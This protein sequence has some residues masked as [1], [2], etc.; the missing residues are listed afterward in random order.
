MNTGHLLT[1]ATRRALSCAG[2]FA[3]IGLLG[4]LLLL[5]TA[6]EQES[7]RTLD[8]KLGYVDDVSVAVDQTLDMAMRR[9]LDVSAELNQLVANFADVSR[10][11]QGDITAIYEPQ[12]FLSYLRRTLM[13][14]F[15]SVGASAGADPLA[16]QEILALRGDLGQ[17]VAQML[18]G[19][20]ALGD[21]H[22]ESVMVREQFSESSRELV[23]D[24]RE[25]G[26]TTLAD[27]IFRGQQQVLERVKRSGASDLEQAQAIIDRLSLRND[28]L[29]VT[30]QERLSVVIDLGQRLTALRE[31]RN[32]SITAMDFAGLRRN[33][34]RLRQITTEDYVYVLSIANEARILL[35]LYTFFLLVG[36]CYFGFRLHRSYHA[37]NRS[38]DDL[39]LRVHERTQEL[40]DAPGEP[41]GVPG[42]AG[43]GRKDVFAGPAG[44]RR[45]ARDQ[46]AAAVRSQQR[47][48]HG[49]TA[50]LVLKELGEIMMPVAAARDPQQ[51][52][53]ALER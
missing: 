35:N 28:L 46:H 43:A 49:M 39:E 14:G 44:G 25:R 20:N 8:A 7:Y 53:S 19:V 18:V 23:R 10:S 21:T 13:N 26:K 41:Q 37:L 51:A 52:R 5:S 17:R 31:G 47:I 30:D 24:L 9:D 40:E 12:G 33:V 45:H 16:A 42:A 50:E 11:L 22:S 1:K 4:A 34:D 2:I 38:H 48:R 15:N 3:A 32:A 29:P 6:P 36:L 27:E